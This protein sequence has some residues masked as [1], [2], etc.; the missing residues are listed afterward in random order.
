MNIHTLR[1]FLVILSSLGFLVSCS[2]EYSEHYFSEHVVF[3]WEA[4]ATKTRP[5]FSSGKLLILPNLDVQKELITSIQHAKH[6]VWIEIYTWTDSSLL[7]AV[8]QAKKRNIDIRVILEGSVYGTPTINNKIYY[9][10][11]N[12]EIPV[13]Y[14]DNYRYTFTHAK[15]FL[16]DDTYFISTGNWTKS[17]FTSNRD[18]IFVDITDEVRLFLEKL[19]LADFAHRAFLDEREIPD[20]IVLSPIDARRKIEDIVDTTKKSISVYVQTLTDTSVLS[21][22]NQLAEEWR[23]VR[24]CTAQNEWNVS[25]SSANSSLRWK[26]IKKPYLHAKVFLIDGTDIFIGSQNMTANSLDNNREVGII[27]RQ[28][29]SLYTL[30][31]SLFQKDCVF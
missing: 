2:S 25:A 30:L 15:F 19:F 29:T 22:L 16:I 24:I 11:K 4:S 12:A 10:L 31:Y 13:V 3:E 5:T 1:F 21:Q 27:I 14:A 18:I 23:E 9:A 26:M 28:N 7:D 8:I 17:F 6:R 20:F